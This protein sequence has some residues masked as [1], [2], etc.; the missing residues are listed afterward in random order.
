[1]KVDGA[2]QGV[3]TQGAAEAEPWAISFSSLKKTS[4]SQGSRAHHTF[5]SIFSLCHYLCLKGSTFFL[6]QGTPFP[7]KTQNNSRFP[8]RF[9]RSLAHFALRV[10]APQGHLSHVEFKAG[11]R[12]G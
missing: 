1:M 12:Q 4:Q 10:A 2:G 8:M 5:P 9:F 7:I 6:F 11:G 3:Q